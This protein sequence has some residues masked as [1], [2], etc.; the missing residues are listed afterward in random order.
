MPDKAK[1]MA[2]MDRN[3]DILTSLNLEAYEGQWVTIIDTEVACT[4]IDEEAVLRETR[5]KYPGR[6]PLLFK[7][8]GRESMAC[9]DGKAEQIRQPE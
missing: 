6:V 4:G 3:F 7:V 1:Q 8:P 5:R 9:E 2:D